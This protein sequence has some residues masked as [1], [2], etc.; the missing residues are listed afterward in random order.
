MRFDFVPANEYS[1]QDLTDVY[2]QT[3]LDYVVPMPMNVAKLREYVE[4]YDIQL[5]H[6][7]VA[8]YKGKPFGLAMLGVRDQQTWVT[9][10]GITPKG[11]RQGVGYA[12]MKAL[13]IRSQQLGAAEMVLEVIDNNM[14]ARY[15]FEG[16]GFK[17]LRELLVIRRPPAII[18]EGVVIPG[19]IKAFGFDKAMELLQSR[20]DIPSWLTDTISMENTGNLSALVGELADG[21]RG[22]VVY[23]NTLF[24]LSR[25][26]VETEQGEPVKVAQFLLQQLHR[27]H[28]FQD[29]VVE[30]VDSTDPH[31]PAYQSLGYFSSF[32]RIEM[33]YDLRQPN[34]FSE[35]GPI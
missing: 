1:L 14:P 22:W 16:M 6:S 34:S 10:L 23:Q 13:I 33:S 29:T 17:H 35:G 7:L 24:Q 8:N 3:R 5:E 21:S 27:R 18:D 19:H 31:W 25:L 4:N 12:L 30:N 9:R 32:V 15:L 11:R 20:T 28:S 26:V 2:N